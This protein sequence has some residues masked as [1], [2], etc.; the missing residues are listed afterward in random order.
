MHP[1]TTRGQLI[2][3]LVGLAVAV[4]LTIPG[5]WLITFAG[6]HNDSAPQDT[7]TRTV[8]V[9]QPVTT[10]EVQ[11]DG[12]PVQVTAGPVQHVRVTETIVYAPWDGGPPTAT[13]SVSGGILTLAEPACDCAVAFTVTIPP[14]VGVAADTQG[15]PLAVSGASGADL[16]SGGGPVRATGISGH[17]IVSANGGTVQLNG[18]TGPLDADTGG[19]SLSAA[20]IDATTVTILTGG[21]PAQIGFTAPPDGMFVST[22]GGPA[23]LSVP[24]GPYALTADT[25]GGP[26]TVGI[27]TDPGVSRSIIVTTGGG[28]LRIEPPKP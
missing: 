25:Y 14:G 7:F 4:S 23:T 12:A 20:G 19:G 9:S 13:Q 26:E 10:V 3:G 1:V 15:G 11:S 6:V 17:L 24:G 27:A 5:A 28:P 2:W 22:D 16:E 21:G 18:L 8:T